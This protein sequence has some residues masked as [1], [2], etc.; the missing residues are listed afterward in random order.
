MR[1]AL[2]QGQL[3]LGL[4]SRHSH[5]RRH[6]RKDL[7]ADN[8]PASAGSAQTDRLDFGAVCA[9][10]DAQ[11]R[12]HS[13]KNVQALAAVDIPEENLGLPQFAAPGT[14]NQLFA[15][16][17][18]GNGVDHGRMATQHAPQ[19][20]GMCLPQA[21]RYDRRRNWPGPGHRD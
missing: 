6:S 18:E 11:A 5:R 2:D 17:A 20:A 21:G 1:G 3:R 10:P 12:T 8:G 14:G 4:V 7:P 19:G 13:R 16:R 9:E 15:I